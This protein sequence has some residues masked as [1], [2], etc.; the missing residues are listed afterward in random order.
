[1][2][3]WAGHHTPVHTDVYIQAHGHTGTHD[4]ML[5]CA[6]QHRVRSVIMALE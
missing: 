3:N 6:D 4:L 5:I 2:L 1:M